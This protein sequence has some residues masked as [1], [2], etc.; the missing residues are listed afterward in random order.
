MQFLNLYNPAWCFPAENMWGKCRFLLTVRS[1]PLSF[2]LVWHLFW[3]ALKHIME[4]PRLGL[5]HIAFLS[6]P[7]TPGMSCPF[8]L[9]SSFSLGGLGG[10][11]STVVGDLKQRVREK[12]ENIGWEPNR[13][14]ES[15]PE[16]R[17]CQDTPHEGLCHSQSLCCLMCILAV[18]RVLS[19][20]SSWAQVLQAV[21]PEPV[22]LLH[23]ASNLPASGLPL[24]ILCGVQPA[25]ARNFE[26]SMQKIAVQLLHSLEPVDVARYLSCYSLFISVENCVRSCWLT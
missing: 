24:A 17:R 2:G 12:K 26:I 7:Y 15:V 13:G 22:A 20:C 14:K 25:L 5:L 8:C 23:G 16:F 3:S 9:V 10:A 21:F 4:Y 1:F 6:S 19:P 11:W 18:T